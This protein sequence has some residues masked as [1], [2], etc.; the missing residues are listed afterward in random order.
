MAETI[1]LES[2]EERQAEARAEGRLLGLG[3]AYYAECTGPGPYEG[4]QIRIHPLTG[5]AHVRTGLTNQGQGHE[6]VFAQIT[7]DVLGC[8]VEDVMVVEGDTGG[9]DW[10]VGTFASRAAVVSGSAIHNTALEVRQQMVDLSADLLECSPEDIV[11]EDGTAYVQGVP[12]RRISFAQIATLSNPL[13]YSHGEAT[14]SPPSSQRPRSQT[15]RRSR[16]EAIPASKRPVSSVRCKTLG[17]RAF[18]PPSWRSI[19]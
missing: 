11:M 4:A 9:F 15:A 17:H 3:L 18:M 6:T 1:D 12:D 10:G 5:K 8:A 2:F 19:R 16:R 14:D 13:R 7:A